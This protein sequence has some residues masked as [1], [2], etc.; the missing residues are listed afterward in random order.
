MEEVCHD[1]KKEPMLLELT[2][3]KGLDQVIGKPKT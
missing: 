1:V 3:E 2:G